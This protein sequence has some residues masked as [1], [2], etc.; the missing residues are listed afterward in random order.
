MKFSLLV[1]FVGLHLVI[2]GC[3]DL[4]NNSAFDP[5]L[6]GCW[7]NS[8]EEQVTEDSL[9]YRP[10]DYL[11]EWPASRYTHSFVLEENGQGSYWVL[12]PADAHYWA[13]CSWT[14]DAATRILTLYVHEFQEER[15]FRVHEITSDKLIL[16]DL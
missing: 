7:I 2:T 4:E 12:H 3:K 8:R 10:C 13:D 9:F 5:M 1:F 11:V 16:S 15:S 6:L 14:F